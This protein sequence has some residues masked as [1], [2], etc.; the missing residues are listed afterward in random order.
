MINALGIRFSA[1]LHKAV[2]SG[3][4]AGCS[5]AP[6]T[7]YLV[8]SGSGTETETACSQRAEL[9]AVPQLHTC[10][11]R[12]SLDVDLLLGGGRNPVLLQLCCNLQP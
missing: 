9:A 12:L 10:T 11:V 2:V 6:G 8:C 3:H 5:W 4:R 1:S 7:R